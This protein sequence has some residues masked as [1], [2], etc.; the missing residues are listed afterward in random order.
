[1][2]SF[3]ISH[4]FISQSLVFLLADIYLP[5]MAFALRIRNDA[6]ASHVIRLADPNDHDLVML[7]VRIWL[8]KDKIEE[9]KR[10]TKK[11]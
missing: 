2:R 9:M 1:L 3:E 8:S 11:D 7:Y 10:R 4:I 6:L 5:E